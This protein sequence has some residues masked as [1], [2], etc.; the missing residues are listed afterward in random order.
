MRH[1]ARWGARET[2]VLRGVGTAWQWFVGD[3]LAV[4]RES[5]AGSGLRERLAYSDLCVGGSSLP[6]YVPTYAC[7]ARIL[8]ADSTALCGMP[9]V[10]CVGP[11]LA[12]VCMVGWW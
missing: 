6:R 2:A 5:R 12:V 8:V 1:G 4:I 3:V 10:I 11:L 9:A 7:T